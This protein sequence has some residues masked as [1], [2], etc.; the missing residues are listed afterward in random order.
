[1]T[2]N[3]SPESHR[4]LENELLNTKAIWDD[5]VKANDALRAA[6][7]RGDI[8]T[9]HRLSLTVDIKAIKAIKATNR[10]HDQYKRIFTDDQ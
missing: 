9:A 4:R 1:M 8:K 10:A 6:I 5:L 3:I 2:T 7:E